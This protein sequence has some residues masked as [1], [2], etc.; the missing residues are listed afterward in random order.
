MA[1]VGRISG[2]VLKSNLV[3]NGIDLAFETDLLYLDTNSQRIGINT[4]SPTHSAFILG[5]TKTNH[6]I[7]DSISAAGFEIN[8]STITAL[9]GNI[10][11]D[12]KDAIKIPTL[13][14]PSFHINDNVITGGQQDENIEL[15]PNGTGSTNIKS[16]L[17]VE[18]N[19]YTP[20]N[21]TF[22]GTIIFG[23]NQSQDT[24]D[25]NSDIDSDIIPNSNDSASLGNENKQWKD[26]YTRL[27]NGETITTT[28]IV[29]GDINYTLKQGNIFFVDIKG[30]DNNTGDHPQDP[31]RTLKRA[32]EA[33]DASV[34]GPVAIFVGAGEFEEEL[35]LSVP[36]NVTIT[37]YDIRN[38]IIKPAAGFETNDVFLLDGETTVQHL[39][40]S[41]FFRNADTGYAFKFK[42]N[43]TITKRSPYV[44]NVTVLTSGSTT[45]QFD[46]R[47]FNAGDAGGGAYLDGAKVD[48]NSLSASML[49]RSVTFITPNS[50]GLVMTNGVRVEWLTSFTYFADKAI[51]G[52]NGAIGRTSE[53]GST[54]IY[55][56]ELRSIGSANVYGNQ[57]AIADGNDCLFYLINH[58]FAYIGTGRRAD[59]DQSLVI[60]SNQIEELNGGRIVYTSID[61]S[62]KYKV[63][64]DFFVDF[65]TGTTTIDASD[66][67]ADSFTQL[68]FVDG[69]SETLINSGQVRTGLLD[70]SSN[71]L[72][73]LSNEINL[74]PENELNISSNTNID[75]N[76]SISGNLDFA[77]SLNLIGNQ[78]TDTVSLNVD[79][80]QDFLPDQDSKFLLGSELKEWSTVWL[81]AANIDSIEI[82][83]NYITTKETNADLEL[84]ANGTGK[85][86]SRTNTDI[87]DNLS[88]LG[89]SSLQ[90]TTFNNVI[91]EKDLVNQGDNIITESVDISQMIDVGSYVDLENI[92]IKGNSVFTTQT[93][94]ALELRANSIGKIRIPFNDVDIK[95]NLYAKNLDSFSN[96]DINSTVDSPRFTISKISIDT[97]YIETDNNDLVF[98]TS[99]AGFISIE[100]L[101]FIDDTLSTVFQ[102][103]ELNPNQNID[104][105]SSGSLQLPVGDNSYSFNLGE[106]RF[107]ETESFFKGFG[108]GTTILQDIYSEDK[109]TSVTAST[110]TNSLTFVANNQTVSEVNSEQVTVFNIIVD[111]FNVNNNQISTVTNNT[112]LVLDRNGT[113]SVNINDI[114]IVNNIIENTNSLLSFNVTEFGS[115]KFDTSTGVVVP[116]GASSNEDATAPTGGV[117]WNTDDSLLEVFDGV[118]YIS[119]AGVSAQVSEEEFN[120]LTELYT[121]VLG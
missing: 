95:T 103:I 80:N 68:K 3:R 40:V 81:S 62:G 121:L 60:E 99:G 12:A 108:A 73:S 102:D 118:N 63:G 90:S 6:T 105:Q 51:L 84:R 4:D 70:F 47:G 110:S 96:I 37:G 35:P 75:Q 74:S 94:S 89:S 87:N 106:I 65:D 116:Y 9:S 43:T 38:T 117:R 86:L 45:T 28:N 77:G 39:T 44:Q 112:D 32:L 57:A 115:Y 48:S 101:N 2:P 79:I 56:A 66:V 54:L 33:V 92:S 1:Q 14:L 46:P 10:F 93:N 22:D 23:D 111:D 98:D 20:G 78:A 24:V 5:T 19:I 76:L 42:P 11:L 83:S 85:I 13:Q 55:G 71:L 21:I 64:D 113:G 50:N 27:V 7:S 15:I 59:N 88:V 72:S 18:G 100:N 29:V 119:A 30:N 58:N 53:D 61:Q 97:N 104:I 16:N 82:E 8:D 26:L 120:E 49:F 41:S 17:N 52:F 114:K 25:F 31:Y 36:N 109:K 67:N 107:D 69:T 34:Q 91:L